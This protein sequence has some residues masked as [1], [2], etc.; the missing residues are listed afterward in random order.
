MSESRPRRA[1]SLIAAPA[2]A[3]AALIAGPACAASAPAATTPTVRI[4]E[5]VTTGDVNDSV[6][7][8]N[9]GAVAVDISGWILRDDQD[10]SKYKIASGATLAAGGFRAFDVHNSFGLG[11]DDQARLFLA[12]GSTLVDQ[13][14][15]TRHSDPSWSRCPDGTGAFG[16]AAVTLGAPN[17][18]GGSGAT[19]V[20]W[21]GGSSVTTADAANV[22]GQDLSGLY[23]EGNVLWG[24]QNSGKLW[25]LVRN[26][27]GWAPD[28]SSG[29]TS[30]KALH[31]PGG[32]GTPDDEGVTLTGAGSAGG[33]FVSSE[34]NADDS[35]TSRTSVLRYD[36]S[37]SGS[38]LTATREWDLTSD[39]P[40]VGANL[41]FEGITWIPDSALTA[42]H[43]LDAATGSAYD[44]SHYGSHAG[45]VF[46][47]GVEGTGMVYGYVLQDSGAHTRVASVSSGMSSV[48]ELQWEPQ[49]SRLWVVCDDTC[50]GQHRTMAI[51]ATGAFATTAVYNRPAG[52]PNYNN[53]GFSVAGA[54]ECAGGAKPVYWSDDG[55]D[56]GHAL[57]RGTITC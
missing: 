41:G 3:A 9:T 56:D 51:N 29:W 25:R 13:F 48:M 26:G 14:S 46:F 57:R 39:L 43:F 8:Y 12:D 34:R 28:T 27:S 5:V 52:M 15:W 22:F 35:G 23:Q 36:V 24:A 40:P 44:P 16:P 54:G 49:A 50:D 42:G 38:T 6:E 32:S 55:N 31:Y 2:L 53:E 20:A 11:S 37:G 4:N 1:W 7:L 17:S 33:V 19:P 21:P 30:G 47:V 18:C 45:G 10:S